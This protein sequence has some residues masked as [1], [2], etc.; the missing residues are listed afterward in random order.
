MSG[1]VLYENLLSFVGL[2]VFS[3]R[4]LVENFTDGVN[5]LDVRLFVFAANVVGLPYP[6]LG[7]GGPDAGA[8]VSDVEPV[9]DVHAVTVD[10]QV[11]TFEGVEDHE[12][13]EFLG[14][15]EG[16]VV[17]GA[18]GGEDWQAV[19]VVVGAHDVVAGGL[20]GGIG[21]VGR[22]GR[23]LFEG[24][25]RLGE[26]AVDLVGGDVQE[27]EGVAGAAFE[28]APVAQGLVDDAQGA[29]DVRLEKGFGGVDGTVDVGLGGEVDD[30]G[31]GVL[32]QEAGNE[33]GVADVTMHELVPCVGGE[34]G[35]VGRVACV[36]E[37][38]Q[39]HKGVDLGGDDGIRQEQA[40]EVGADESGAAGD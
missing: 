27:A 10:G 17:V 15:L 16:A 5:D 14:K 37:F 32:S 36:G 3:W 39:V 9:A 30:V 21:A 1:A 34:V 11:L 24:G 38:V 35:E 20:G 8:V 2:T 18:V 12:R 19:G 4:F 13:D 22:E 7:E 29:D 6:T 31:D 28:A 40:G 33:V 26:G 25:V 23:G